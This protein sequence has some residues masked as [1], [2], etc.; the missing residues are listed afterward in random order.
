MILSELMGKKFG[1]ATSRVLILL[2]RKR[3]AAND[4]A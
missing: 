2:H 3:P 4:L 1:S